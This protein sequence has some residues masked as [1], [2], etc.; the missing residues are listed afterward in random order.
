MR[1]AFREA[2]KLETAGRFATDRRLTGPILLE[3]R[4]SGLFPPFFENPE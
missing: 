3:R 4:L 1:S 2:L